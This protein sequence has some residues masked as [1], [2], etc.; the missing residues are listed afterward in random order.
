MLARVPLC[1]IPQQCHSVQRV[2]SLLTAP[3]L[4]R[5]STRSSAC[6]STMPLRRY[7]R[8]QD[9]AHSK[10]VVRAD[11]ESYA[12]A[13]S[14]EAQVFAAVPADG[15][16]LA[17]LKAKLPGDVADLGFRQAMQQK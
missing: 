12:T 17:D 13:G 16:T 14:P 15:I 6:T 5:R 1:K 11:S 7:A 8:P 3:T 2:G 9:I 10:Y 4:L